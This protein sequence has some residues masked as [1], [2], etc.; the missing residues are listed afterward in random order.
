MICAGVRVEV[1]PPINRID[2]A[3]WIHGR[4]FSPYACGCA[5]WPALPG[6]HSLIVAG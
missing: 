2:S 3:F 6:W 4:A 1:D 5:A